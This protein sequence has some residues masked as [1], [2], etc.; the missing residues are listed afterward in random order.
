MA[1][2][3]EMVKVLVAETDEAQALVTQVA[4]NLQNNGDLPKNVGR[5]VSKV[6][7]ADVSLLLLGIYTA[8]KHADASQRAREYTSLTWGG[9][10]DGL[11]FGDFLT[12]ALKDIR[13]DRR[14]RIND[15]IAAPFDEIRIEIVT[16]YPLVG[17]SCVPT[18]VGPAFGGTVHFARTPRD[19][20]RWRSSKPRR[21]VTIPGYA[22]FNIVSRL[23][24]FSMPPEE[25]L[26]DFGDPAEG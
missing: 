1:T 17:V 24:G 21:S 4:R 8:T 5:R 16:S 9:E 18:L 23:F 3:A 13:Q 26:Y 12:G 25:G 11:L 14:V 10:P 7:E 19:A 2:V 15:A 6:S 22:L 20:R